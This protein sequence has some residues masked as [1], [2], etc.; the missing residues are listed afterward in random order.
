MPRTA[1][2][3]SE[4]PIYGEVRERPRY[5]VTRVHGGGGG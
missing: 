1:K 5:V 4:A 3:G 2:H